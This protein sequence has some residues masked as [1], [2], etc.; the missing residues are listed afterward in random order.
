MS[1]Y[2]GLGSTREGLSTQDPTIKLWNRNDCSKNSMV[3]S[4]GI[5]GTQ[6]TE[7]KSETKYRRTFL[8][9]NDNV[10]NVSMYRKKPFD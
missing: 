6:D 4:E 9:S 8:G 5:N 3:Q 10:R 2:R 7:K 1:S